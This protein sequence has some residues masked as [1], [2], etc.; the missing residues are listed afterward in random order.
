MRRGQGR[1]GKAS[2]DDAGRLEVTRSSCC[3]RTG[4]VLRLPSRLAVC[5]F[6]L[7]SLGLAACQD[8]RPITEK[9]AKEIV[10]RHLGLVG[11]NSRGYIDVRRHGED[12]AVL[13]TLT[14]PPIPGGDVL[15]VVSRDG[16]IL[17]VFPGM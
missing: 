17:D 10:L 14:D 6:L 7:L 1:V 13:V 2:D 8:S 5:G 4:A 12:W 15:V 16:K 3:R 9:E 11:D